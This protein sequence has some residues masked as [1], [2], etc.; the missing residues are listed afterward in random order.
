MVEKK[1]FLKKFETKSDYDLQEN[2]IMNKNHIVLIND[3]Q[4]IIFDGMEFGPTF[5]SKPSIPSSSTAFYAKQYFTVE[6]LENGTF[7]LVMASGATQCMYRLN[8]DANEW[9]HVTSNITF[10]LNAQDTIE[11]SCVNDYWGVDIHQ[12]SPFIISGKF[13]L[14]GNIMSLLYG[15]DFQ[16][17][18]D[19]R[20]MD[21][22]FQCMFQNCTNL[23]SAKDLV[24]PAT[25]LS[26][27]CYCYM[28]RGCTSLTSAPELLAPTLTP[29]CYLEMF[30]GCN[31]LNYIK[32]LATNTDASSCL[33]N[34]TYGVAE[35]GVFV[36]SC[37]IYF[38]DGVIPSGWT[39]VKV[40][41]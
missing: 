36:K 3:T 5:P 21:R 1:R 12:S 8:G 31:S 30:Y 17:E 40:H 10:S 14:K 37:S 26:E 13:N 19:L 32:M 33:R 35:N 29:N 18:N 34:W 20:G 28:F 6:M 27:E 9:K 39:V 24:L 15:D 11:L 22:V 41:N 25:Q 16:N 7:E 23:V 2:L 38:P 4:N